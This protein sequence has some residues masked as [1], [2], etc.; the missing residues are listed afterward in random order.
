MSPT[1][2]VTGATGFAGS[3]VLESLMQLAH[4][5]IRVIAACRDRRRLLPGFEGDV[6]EGDLRD[7]DYLDRV[8]AGADIVC[9]CAAWSALYGHRKQSR[10]LFLEPSLALIDKALEWR[11]KRF[12]FISTISAAA[13]QHS[14][15]A[16][17]PGI[18]RRFW[19]HLNHVIEI[20]NAMR[21]NAQRGMSM[22]NLRFGLFAGKRYSL[23]ILPVLLPRLRNRLLPWVAGGRTGLPLVAGQ[24]VAQAVVRAALAPGLQVYESI[25][26]VGPDIPDTREVINY[27][28]DNHH[29]PKPLFSLPFFAAYGFAWLMEWLS[30]LLAREPL[31]TRSIVHLLQDTH[32]NNDKAAALLGY[33]PDVHW[34][35]AV[36]E[37]IQQMQADGFTGMQLHQAV[38][39]RELQGKGPVN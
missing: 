1:I 32:A 2:V 13:P 15:E 20:E 24:D 10:Q 29:Y 16:S 31:L 30:P 14:H 6:R 21:D 38:N 4:K 19:P 7:Q 33:S 3:H 18:P 37:Q 28:C 36:D 12:V 27:I 11:L 5:D 39:E 23:G 9:H 8:L 22:V 35:Q 25:N 17:S 26:I 34:K